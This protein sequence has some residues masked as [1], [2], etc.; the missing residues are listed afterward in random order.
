MVRFASIA[1]LLT[2]ALS[3]SACGETR[4][5]RAG[6]GAVIGG[7]IGGGVGAVCCM[8]PPAGIKA[9]ALIGAGTGAVVGALLSE[10]LFMNHEA[11][12]WPYDMNQQ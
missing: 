1:L 8:N 4:L 2:A 6:S 9:G 10:P 7:V 5:E 12:Y 3:L 11:Q